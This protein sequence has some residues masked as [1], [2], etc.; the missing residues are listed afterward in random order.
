M[1]ILY[2]LFSLVGGGTFFIFICLFLVNIMV[3]ACPAAHT[4]FYLPRPQTSSFWGIPRYFQAFWEMCSFWVVPAASI[5]WGVPSLGSHWGGILLRCSNYLY[6][7][8]DLKEQQL[9]FKVTMDHW[10]SSA[11]L[12]RIWPLVHVTLVIQLLTR[13]YDYRW[14]WAPHEYHTVPTF[15]YKA[16]YKPTPDL[17]YRIRK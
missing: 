8:L 1:G 13:A 6:W 12:H 3:A 9:F 16:L 14:G 10:V 2:T 17:L 5:Q 15:I 4:K 7:L 11:T